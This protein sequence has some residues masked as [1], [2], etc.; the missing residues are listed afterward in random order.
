MEDGPIVEEW[1][2]K[3]RFE[4]KPYDIRVLVNYRKVDFKLARRSDGPITNLHLNNSGLDFQDLGLDFE[5]ERKIEELA[6]KA[7]GSFEGLNCGGVDI[8]LSRSKKLYVIE[9]NGQG[10]LLYRDIYGDNY[11]YKRQ[12][13][14]M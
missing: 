7:V 6:K 14:R 1:I 10:V 8:L 5:V 3:S 9:V 11:I 4:N 13:E 2:E 12:I